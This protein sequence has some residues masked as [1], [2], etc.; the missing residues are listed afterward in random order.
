M[1]TKYEIELRN[2]ALI[3]AAVVGIMVMT[4]LWTKYQCAMPQSEPE[5]PPQEILE[6]ADAPPEPVAGTERS[7]K[8]QTVKRHWL[9]SNPL[10]VACGTD[11]QLNVH[12]IKPFH[13][14]PELELDPTNL[15]T[16]CR[17]HHFVIGHDPDGPWK[18][19]KPDWATAN[20]NVL[21]DA[22]KWKAKR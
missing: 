12:H 20:P 14:N 16:L 21:A 6:S 17:V 9:L 11:V 18:S 2:N 15:I 3:Y 10:C 7:G 5:P 13:T 8:W 22:K 19:A 4:L 1:K